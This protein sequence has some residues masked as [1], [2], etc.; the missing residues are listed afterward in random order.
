MTLGTNLDT[1]WQRIGARRL[2]SMYRRSA[3]PDSLVA[4][5][6]LLFQD[7]DVVVLNVE[8]AIGEG[9]AKTKC[10]PR[11]RN[12]Y[13]FRG[14]PGSARALRSLGD[15]GA[16]VVGN[17][18]NNHARDAGPL[19]VDSTIAHLR[20]AGVLVTGADTLA[21]P[22]VLRDST[23][24]GVLGFYSGDVLTDARDTTAVRRHVARAVEAY[25]T[26]VVTAHLGAEGIGA[27]RTRDSTELFL[28]WKIDRGN[29]VAFAHAAL[30][31]G[32]SLV[33]GHGPHVLRAAEWRD[34]GL[35]FYSLGNLLTY[36]PFNNA[37]PINRG[38]IACADLSGRIVIGSDI[39]PTVQ[40]APGVVTADSTGR[41][42]FLIDSLSR[43]DFPV[44]GVRVDSWGDL[45]RVNATGQSE[46]AKRD[47]RP[48]RAP[49]SPSPSVG[50][51][52]Q[53]IRDR[54]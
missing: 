38:V 53:R 31:G 50:R 3:E 10:G 41:A 29:P 20:R 32:A 22:V 11:S 40:V 30:A 54:E 34:E 52:V 9:P 25:G 24:L 26:V 47:A 17:V 33:L 37:E 5:I 8:T 4:P 14:P 49:V 18:A 28:E 1:A 19:G 44:T 12:C 13:A 48:D 6:R 7:A 35:V 27:Q 15:S 21:T 39:R 51:G 2:R 42:L 46:P 36:G 16:V 45:Y 43:L 23:R